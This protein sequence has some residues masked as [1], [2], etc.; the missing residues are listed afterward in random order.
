MNILSKE[1]ISKIFSNVDTILSVNQKIFNQLTERKKQYEF[2]I[3]QF[4]DI[5]LENVI[6]QY[7]IIQITKF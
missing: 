6:N 3:E 5:I 2:V 4:G 1:D 7:S